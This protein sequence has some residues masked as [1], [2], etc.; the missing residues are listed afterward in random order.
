M[1]KAARLTKAEIQRALA[2]AEAAGKQ[3]AIRP[4][5]TLVFEEK[6][7]DSPQIAPGWPEEPAGRRKQAVF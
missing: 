6:G 5:G 3:L 1:T 2:V 4:D 7:V